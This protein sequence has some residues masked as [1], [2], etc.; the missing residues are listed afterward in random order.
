MKGQ[1]DWCASY[2]HAQPQLV[3]GVWRCK[4]CGE[5]LSRIL[6]L[7]RDAPGLFILQCGWDVG[8]GLVRVTSAAAYALDY[9]ERAVLLS[10]TTPGQWAPLQGYR[11]DEVLR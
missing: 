8:C 2:G 4:G 3:G 1:R 11:P 10:P 6:I 7:R 9:E 5:P